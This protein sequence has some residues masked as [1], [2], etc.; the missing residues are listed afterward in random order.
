MTYLPCSR[1]RCA[2]LSAS[3]PTGSQ[4]HPAVAI[5]ANSIRIAVSLSQHRMR[6]RRLREELRQPRN[7]QMP[8][9]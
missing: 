3:Y 4:E 6:L 5:G 8:R 1:F 9:H 7:R 2:G